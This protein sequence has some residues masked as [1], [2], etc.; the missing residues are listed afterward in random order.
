M[1]PSSPGPTKQSLKRPAPPSSCSVF[2][3][4]NGLIL[5]ILLDPMDRYSGVMLNRLPCK[6]YRPTC[7]VYTLKIGILFLQAQ[8]AIQD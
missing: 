4:V 6:L 3:N 7:K 2:Q 5:P 8:T 1:L